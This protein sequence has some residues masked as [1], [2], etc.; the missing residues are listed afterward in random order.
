MKIIHCADI[1]LDS[2]LTANFTP[3]QA[4][5]RK[6]E[7]VMTFIRMVEY[8]DKNQVSAI[9]IAGD[10]FDKKVIGA[11]IRNTIYELFE[12]YP[13][14][15]FYYL[16]GN[17]DTSS[18]IDNMKE[19]PHNLFLF[20]DKWTKY[21][22]FSTGDKAV[23]LS[24]VELNKDNSRAVYAE[25]VL[26]PG[27]CNIVTMH[28]Q[29]TQY[30]AKDKAEEIDLG[31]LRNKNISYLALGHIHEYSEG[32]LHPGGIYCYSGCLEGRG[33]DESGEH[34]F[35]L[36]DIDENDLQLKREFIPFADRLVHIINV[37]VSGCDSSMDMIDRIK[38]EIE[39]KDLKRD[40]VKLVLCGKVDVD[41]E[42]NID[43]I[44]R[45]FDGSFYCHK[46]EDQT[47]TEIDYREYEKDMSLKGE[48]V[49]LL[50]KQTELDEADRMAVIRCG[51][52]VLKGEEI[53]I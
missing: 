2:A 18:F 50:E 15:N 51:L 40:L 30:K 9:I 38:S 11:R 19:L 48:F 42:K 37:D 32:V 45:Y 47:V 10:L 7:L 23:T 33:Y 53:E 5:E 44:S 43:L 13:G 28:G 41:C 3:E 20:S 49:R 52:Q 31:A 27:D 21:E 35:V 25:L 14:I 29:I 8:A 34:G 39:G 16:Q 6:N 26:K 17:H 1:H 4:K 24:G 36:L 46:L 12:K 22:L